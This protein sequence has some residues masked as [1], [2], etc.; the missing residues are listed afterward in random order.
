MEK[1]LYLLLLGFSPGGRG[2]L[3]R[4]QWQLGMVT[5]RV[6]SAWRLRNVARPG[7]TRD[8][9][10]DTKAYGPEALPTWG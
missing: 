2:W 9:E 4:G 8:Q 3:R 10:C 1:P 6:S 7:V 5:A